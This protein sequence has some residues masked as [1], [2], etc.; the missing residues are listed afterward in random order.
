MA[1]ILFDERVKQ[2]F[3]RDKRLLKIINFFFNSHFVLK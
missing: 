2:I 3:N 1:T